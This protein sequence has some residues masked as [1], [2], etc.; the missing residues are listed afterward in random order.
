MEKFFT[1]SSS[2][3]DSTGSKRKS[4]SNDYNKDYDEKKRQR[5]FQMKEK[6]ERFSWLTIDTEWGVM[7]CK[8]CCCYLQSLYLAQ[9]Q[10]SV[11]LG[12]T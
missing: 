5:L 8:I 4:K 7:K 6:K 10:S 2:T 1:K 11:L 9:K 3:G 12:E